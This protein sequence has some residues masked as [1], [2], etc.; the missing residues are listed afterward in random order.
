MEHPFVYLFPDEP[1]P[2]PLPSPVEPVAVAPV[3]RNKFITQRLVHRDAL[4]TIAIPESVPEESEE[5][6]KTRMLKKK[7]YDA[8][9]K[10]L[11]RRDEMGEVR[12]MKVIL[13][14]MHALGVCN[15]VGDAFGRKNKTVVCREGE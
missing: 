2:S 15:T 12:E 6:K 8:E 11:T 5:E 1:A 3:T 9:R 10:R 13:T 14:R 7:A 4:K